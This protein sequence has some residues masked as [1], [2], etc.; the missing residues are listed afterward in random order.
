MYAMQKFSALFFGAL[1]FASCTEERTIS[2]PGNL[3]PPTVEE[4]A[5]LPSIV[6]NGIRLHAEAFGHPDSTLVVCLHGGPGGDYRYLLNAKSL[7]DHGYRVVFYD[8]MGS[9]LSQRIHRKELDDKGIGVLDA[10]YDE[11]KGVIALYR[12]HPEQKVILFGHSWGAILA[13]GFAGRYPNS[14]QGLILCEP[15]GLRWEDIED[16]IERSR[17]FSL[18]GERL[19]DLA[20]LDQ[21][22][23]G[24]RNAHAV[25][26]YKYALATAQNPVTGEDNTKAGSFWRNGAVFS[27]ALIDIGEREHPDFA[28]GISQISAPVL[29]FYTERNKAYPDSWAAHISGAYPAAELYKIMGTGHSGP[30]FEKRIWNETTLPKM[31]SFLNA[32]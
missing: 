20:Y 28:Q 12:T 21:F 13:T 23:T 5:N 19:N 11:L 30:V 25:L 17:N 18:L 7:A 24:H 16:Y 4:D 27:E 29:F 26:D 31:L 32:L 10:L 22:I 14:F 2:D 9:G 1:L 15:G 3:V 6:I 8:Q